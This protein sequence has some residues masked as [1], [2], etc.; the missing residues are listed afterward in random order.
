MVEI[1]SPDTGRVSLSG[2]GFVGLEIFGLK[3]SLNGIGVIVA[4]EEFGIKTGLIPM[5]EELSFP[6]LNEFDRVYCL[7][8]VPLNDR[9]TRL[10]L[11]KDL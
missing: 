2:L 10:T 3:I 7:P 1:D 5:Q 11:M 9:E 6:G 8:L 4:S